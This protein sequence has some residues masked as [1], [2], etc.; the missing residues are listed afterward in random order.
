MRRTRIAERGAL[1]LLAAL[2]AALAGPASARDLHV[3]GASPAASDGAA[4][5]PARPLKTISAAVA[6]AAA[7]DTIRIAGGTYREFIHFP[8]GGDGPGRRLRLVAARGAR[9]T[10]KGSDVVTG[11]Q[12]SAQ[13]GWKR[14]AWT[15]NSQQVFVDG[16]P[17]R[18]VGATSPL[19]AR[20]WG[21]RPILPVRGRGASDLFPGSFFYDAASSTLHVRLRRDADPN[22]HLV[23]ASVRDVVVNAGP[24]GH[25]ELRGLEFAHSN[26]SAG[27]VLRGIV[28]IEG[29]GWVVTRCRFVRGDLAGLS[30]SG[31]GHRVRDSVASQNGAVGIAID[32]SDAAHGWAPYAGRAPQDIVL[33]GNETSRNNT[34]GFLATY[35]AGGVKAANGCNGVR[36]SRH[37]ARANAGPGIWF[38]LGCHDVVVQGSTLAGNTRGIEYETSDR[39]LISRNVITGSAEHGVY[40]NAS[41][42]V[43]VV[44]NRLE[45]NRW[46]IVLHGLPRAEHPRL[47]RV[48]LRGNVVARSGA[49]DLVLYAGPGAAGIT[50]DHNRFEGAGAKLSWTRTDRYDVTHRDLAAFAAAT[51]QD[52]HSS[53]AV[54]GAPLREARATPARGGDR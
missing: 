20:R 53:S 45:G 13:G 19:H 31:N 18:Q 7:G 27:G 12:R 1:P 49:A 41:S 26:T 11:W 52:R 9:V 23:E 14:S 46:G 6:R 15:V 25:V 5:T 42:D 24:V 33:E 10:V 28:N 51:G 54:P 36:I 2:A 3:D 37:V 39:A 16:R 8:R 4:G 17:L 40:V 34:R 38:D 22:E 35:H 29:D 32:G 43:S 48:R 30:L 50:S 21:G 44:E 47:E